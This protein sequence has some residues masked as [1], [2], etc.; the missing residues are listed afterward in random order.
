[1]I[2]PIWNKSD[3]TGGDSTRAA[4]SLARV[5]RGYI[6]CAYLDSNE[7]SDKV[8]TTLFDPY[9]HQGWGGS[10]NIP[11]PG[12]DIIRSLMPPAIG[13]SGLSTVIITCGSEKDPHGRQPAAHVIGYPFN[14]DQLGDFH[15]VAAGG[16]LPLPVS[17]CDT[18][19]RP[20]LALCNGKMVF[21]YRSINGNLRAVFGAFD[22]QPKWAGEAEI[23]AAPISDGPSLAVFKNT[24]YCAYL[25][26]GGLTFIQ[27]SA[28]GKSWSP[29]VEIPVR[30]VHGP[31]L[32]TDPH[33]EQLRLIY[34]QAGGAKLWNVTSANGVNWSTPEE[35]PDAT[36]SAAPAL[37]G[38]AAGLFLC[39]YK[40]EKGGN[41]YS[42]YTK[43]GA[44]TMT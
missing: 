24:F 6:L 36:T 33:E 9:V 13:Y 31:A 29:A 18:A 25:R 38:S 32:S 8:Y 43:Q 30:P 14:A 4:V 41:L 1:M 34:V 39:V 2:D 40:D 17:D 7:H 26:P 10:P 23:T 12:R 42:T 22:G 3:R 44:Y 37:I 20:A 27:N 28:D 15:Q 11:A 21:A 19:T 16:A 35:H 5:W